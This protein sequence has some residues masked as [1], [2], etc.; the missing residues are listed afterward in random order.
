[1]AT[2]SFKNPLLSLILFFAGLALLVVNRWLLKKLKGSL[3]FQYPLISVIA[4]ENPRR[5]GKRTLM[6]VCLLILACIALASPTV[7][8]K[9]KVLREVTG[10]VEYSYQVANP[11]V[12]IAMDVSGSMSD[13]IPGGVKI[14]AAKKAIQTFLKEIPEGIDVG[15]IAFSGELVAQV[16]I[17]DDRSAVEDIVLQLEP[18]GGTMYSNPMMTALSWLRAY[19]YFNIPCALVFVTDGMPADVQEYRNILSELSNAGI[20]VFSVYI[21]PKGD[22]GELET[23]YMAEQTGGEQHTAGTVQNLV[24]SLE[25]LASKVGEVVGRVEVKTHVEEYVE[26]QIPLSKYPLLLLAVISFSLWWI[27]QREEGTFF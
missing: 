21:G 14:E 22:K 23:K 5:E 2:I 17:T 20:P 6:K 19:R 4:K 27:S 8:V 18:E 11:A 12:V 24:Q 7:T 15:L 3:V 9:R 13:T 26:S 25:D 1:M 10:E 16:P